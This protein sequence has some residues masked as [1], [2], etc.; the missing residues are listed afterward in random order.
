MSSTPRELPASLTRIPT[1]PASTRA[2][3]DEATTSAPMISATAITM[4]VRNERE[5]LVPRG[6]TEAAM[7]AGVA[8]D[9]AASDRDRGEAQTLPGGEISA[10]TRGARPRRAQATA[11]A[12]D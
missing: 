5:G 4:R 6:R 8:R 1:C 11:L 3:H 7:G 12:C 2:V 9:S 10:R